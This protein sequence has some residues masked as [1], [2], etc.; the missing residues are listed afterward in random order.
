MIQGSSNIKHGCEFLNFEE[1]ELSVKQKNKRTNVYY[2]HP[3]SSWER[4]ANENTNKCIRYFLPNTYITFKFAIFRFYELWKM[5]LTN[6]T[7]VV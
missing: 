3:Y 7:E 2:T 6:N 4:G 1:I 5:L